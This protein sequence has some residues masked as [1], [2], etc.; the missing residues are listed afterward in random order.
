MEQKND[1]QNQQES[2]RPS[3][4]T[5]AKEFNYK[6]VS[7]DTQLLMSNLA[8]VKQQLAKCII[9]GYGCVEWD[10][11]ELS[12]ELSYNSSKRRTEYNNQPYK[13]K[14]LEEGVPS[15]LIDPH[16]E[17]GWNIAKIF[18]YNNDD[19]LIEKD[20][21][22]G[23]IQDMLDDNYNYGAGFANYVKI[24]PNKDYGSWDVQ[25]SIDW[26]I[27]NSSAVSKHLCAKYVRMALEAGGLSTAGRP[28][29][30][31]NYH[32]QGFLS[33]IGF[34][35][36]ATLP[37]KPEQ[38]R[39]TSQYAEPGDISVMEGPSGK[40]GHICMWTGKQW[41]S[42]FR[43]PHMRPYASAGIRTTECWIY[44]WHTLVKQEAT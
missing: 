6:V 11:N 10:N 5:D 35:W 14:Q 41:I 17:I 40:E 32:L 20:Y 13:K 37:D 38:A 42:D 21:R 19:K 16:K 23:R 44:R 4:S 22:E 24:D 2:K 3:T 9:D 31:K 34:Q 7:D 27:T 43:Q 1:T 30:A 8:F 36:I 29:W 33:K 26:I 15:S 18:Y 25:K 28:N 39:W 12:N